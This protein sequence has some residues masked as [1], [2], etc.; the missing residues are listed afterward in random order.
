MII[1]RETIMENCAVRY[2]EDREQARALAREYGRLKVGEQLLIIVGTAPVKLGD[3]VIHIGGLEHF[4][5]D[6][7]Y[8]TFQVARLWD[9]EDGRRGITFALTPEGE[10]KECEERK[11]RKG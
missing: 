5:D 10:A 2:V 6:E 9:A 11:K 3:E 1:V 8:H 7:N 4:D